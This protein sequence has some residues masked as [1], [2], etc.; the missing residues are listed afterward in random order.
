M[1]YAYGPH[2]N[3]IAAPQF[4]RNWGAPCE[5]QA[6]GLDTK[7]AMPMI[8]LKSCAHGRK[9]E[10]TVIGETQGLR[11]RLPWEQV[12]LRS[13]EANPWCVMCQSVTGPNRPWM[14][15]IDRWQDHPMRCR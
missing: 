7:G 1:S 11:D 2:E 6:Q 3:V 15:K 4:G 12:H 14:D 8:T 13:R 5:G 10:T 9:P